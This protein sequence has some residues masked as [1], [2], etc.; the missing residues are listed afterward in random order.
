MNLNV[1]VIHVV[2]LT[3]NYIHVLTIYVSSTFLHIIMFMYTNDMNQFEINHPFM[4]K[5]TKCHK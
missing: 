5:C 2:Q 3:C 4:L 1:L